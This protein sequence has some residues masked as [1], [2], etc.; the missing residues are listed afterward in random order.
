MKHKIVLSWSGGKDCAFALHKLRNEAHYEVCALL[1]S[2]N[3]QNNEVSMH[4]IPVELLRK[5]AASLGIRL[6]LVQLPENPANTEYEA[7][8]DQQLKAYKQEGIQHVAFGDLFLE[9][10]KQYRISQMKKAGMQAIFPVWGMDTGSFAK[11]FIEEGF[12]TIVSCIDNTQLDP[13][14]T[15]REYDHDFLADLPENADPCGENGEFH[16]FVYDGPVF[17][18][19]LAFNK[20][21]ISLR[22]N[23]FHYLGITA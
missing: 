3:K 2:I 17:K 1:T 6:D 9:D 21:K 7:L 18:Q 15:G 19:P 14:F 10:I 16:T 12:R 22:N 8:M 13:A 23:R 5:Q 11:S 20:G 4:G